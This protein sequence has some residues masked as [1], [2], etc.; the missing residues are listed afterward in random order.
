ML[1]LALHQLLLGY[2]HSAY[3]S[4]PFQCLQ[5]CFYFWMDVV[6]LICICACFSATWSLLH[7]VY[8]SS[9]WSLFS[10]FFEGGTVS[11][12]R[13]RWV[14]NIHLKYFEVQEIILMLEIEFLEL[15]APSFDFL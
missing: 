5:L 9:S 15:V 7:R 10:S 1:Q 4:K 8:M 6:K 2:M 13:G 11:F 14:L 3:F 12:S